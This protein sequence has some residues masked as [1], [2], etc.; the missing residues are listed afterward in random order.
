MRHL[1]FRKLILVCSIVIGS[2]L[3]LC[4]A[5]AEENINVN[6]RIETSE[7]TILDQQISIPESCEVTD[8]T[9]VTSTYTGYKAIC[10][11]QTV[12]EQGL[13]NYGTN[14]FG[15]G[16]FVEK[17]NSIG[18]D[19][20]M[21]WSLYQNNNATLLGATDLP[22]NNNDKIVFSYVDWNYTNE[23]L[24]VD[25][26]NTST[27]TNSPV[28]IKAQFWNSG[29][30]T[31]LNSEATFFI[32][33]N[34][35]N[36]TSGTLEYIPDT[37]GEKEIYIEASGKTRSEKIYL[38][39]NPA[40]KSEPTKQVNL[41]LRYQNNLIFSSQ[42]EIP[43]STIILDSNG[44]EHF[45]TSSNALTALMAADAVSTNF[46]ITDLQYYDSM[47][48]FYLN[49]IDIYSPTNTSLCAN[50]NYVVDDTY[51]SI[52]MDSYDLDGGENI[53]IYFDNPWQITASTSTFTLDTTTTF[54]TW[55]YDYENLEN[56]W[57]PDANLIDISIDNPNSTGWWDTTITIATTTTDG[58]GQVDYKF[59]TTG[60]YYA[61]ITSDDYS[62]WSNP[63]TLTIIQLNT[64]TDDNSKNNNDGGSSGGNGSNENIHNNLNVN[65]AIEFLSSKQNPDGSLGSS[66]IYT[67]WSA[68]AFGAYDKN[69][70]IAQNIKTYLLTDPNPL[71]GLNNVSDYARRAMALMA[72][73][74]NPYSDTKTNYITNLINKFDGTQFGNVNLYNDDIFAI[75]PLLHAGYSSNDNII[76][77]TVEF[78]LSKQS[79][80]GWGSADLTAAAIQ[81]LSPISDISGVSEA[82][83]KA[84][85]KLQQSQT[86]NGDFGGT[87]TTAWVMQ[88]INALNE[89]QADWQKDNKT[90]G[91]YLY[92]IQAKDGGVDETLS[93]DFRIWNTAYVTPAALGKN[94]NDILNNFEK[95]LSQ[96]NSGSD[97][98]LNITT[99]TITTPTTTPTSTFDLTTTTPDITT[100][101]IDIV[102]T[103]LEMTTTSDDIVTTTENIITTSTIA[104]E[105]TK[106]N[107]EIEQ[108]F[109]LPA[110]AG[111]NLTNNKT[112]MQNKYQNLEPITYNLTSTPTMEQ[113]NNVTI[114]S[115]TTTSIP[116]LNT[117]KGVFAT[118]TTMAS[119]L[120]LYLGWKFLQTLL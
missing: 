69:N 111:K 100:T 29:E 89:K 44:V 5:Y 49:C 52:G 84:K 119:G 22:V 56:E 116:Y 78:I 17:I 64:S 4:P 77:K 18:N 55:R 79:N 101:T 114:S 86:N 90:P 27:Y 94:W 8:N 104:Y 35:Y 24:H 87:P 41:N 38:T 59:T 46:T 6:L 88:A 57:L 106:N 53:Y 76:Q 58:S 32:D 66:S 3:F 92:S 67:D 80:G 51:P 71:V 34:S 60:T 82:L 28:N 9:G 99:T 96:N 117:V 102:T 74:I 45:T 112:T 16:L 85:I 115:P 23:I 36:S 1:T 65:K 33:G 40:I 107:I 50:W 7:Q 73:D 25:L 120:G 91:D 62:K 105:D 103:T 19:E 108:K 11:L 83:T 31:N 61:K 39:V 75:I 93:S 68:I 109:N 20:N 26:T 13:L 81:A 37:E 98:D 63:I 118:A 43:T 10:I 15:W 42:I 14:N 54:F 110:Q 72:L 2:I 12:Q 113:F 48:S 21:F 95:P 97:N 30:I 70:T 47:D